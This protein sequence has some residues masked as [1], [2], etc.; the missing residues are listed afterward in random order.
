[1]CF[2]RADFDQI[3]L[4]YPHV[5]EKCY[6][7]PESIDQEMAKKYDKIL[8][9]NLASEDLLE[10]Q[11]MDVFSLGCVLS[12]LFMDS[13]ALFGYKDLLSYKEN[14]FLVESKLGCIRDQHI[15]GILKKMVSLKPDE[16]GNFLE[17]LQYFK[18]Y[19]DDRLYQLLVFL[20]YAFRKSEFFHPDIKLGLIKI[21]SDYICKLAVGL[22]GDDIMKEVAQNLVF[23]KYFPY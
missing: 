8:I 16:R 4:F 12:E 14:E 19:F 6:R 3:K 9:A 1:M 7:A 20:N 15:A 2:D 23:K 5:V 13:K 17:Y 10:L 21:L 22:S 11:K 18:V